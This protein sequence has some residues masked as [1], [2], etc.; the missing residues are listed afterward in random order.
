MTLSSSTIFYNSHWLDFFLF[1]SHSGKSRWINVKNINI[2]VVSLPFP[3]SIIVKMPPSWI[4]LAV[5]SSLLWHCLAKGHTINKLSS[6]AGTSCTPLLNAAHTYTPDIR[7]CL[8]HLLFS[9]SP[10]PSLSSNTQRWIWLQDQ[11]WHIIY[12]G[13]C[14]NEATGQVS[15]IQ[16]NNRI[17]NNKPMF[18]WS[19]FTLWNHITF[20]LNSQWIRL[21][22][23][24]VSLSV[25]LPCCM[26]RGKC[27]VTSLHV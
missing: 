17:L 23:Q 2:Y 9:E 14:H 15:K 22:G 6:R 26:E 3:V 8:C 27:L 11:L 24:G 5:V 25:K 12:L 13:E 10:C 18:Y 20:I 19:L 7:A 16:Q 21:P 4:L 1:F